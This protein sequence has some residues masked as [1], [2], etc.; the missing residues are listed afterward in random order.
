MGDAS[1]EVRV[2]NG[3]AVVKARGR[4]TFVE[5]HPL[6]KFCMRMMEQ[7]I[8]R[9]ILDV[10]QCTSMDSTFIGV[11]AMVSLKGKGSGVRVEICGADE[12]VSGQ[13][14]GL[15]LKRIFLFHD[16]SDSAGG[17]GTELEE[18]GERHEVRE[19]MLEAHETLAEADAGNEERFKDVLT[20][21]RESA[22]S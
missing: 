7:G 11:L 3:E 17:P 16:R 2:T 18:R 21:L 10:Q 5:A 6:R 20:Y 15:G 9:Y 12:Q 13:I 14:L 4:M 19:T 8:N 22:Q 1:V